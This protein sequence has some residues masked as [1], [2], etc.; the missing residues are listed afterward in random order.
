[1][2]DASTVV[3]LIVSLFLFMII[4]VLFMQVSYLND[5]LSI[6]A[7]NQKFSDPNPDNPSIRAYSIVI[8]VEATLALKDENPT[9]D[10]SN[11]VGQCVMNQTSYANVVPTGN[12]KAYWIVIRGPSVSA[13]SS[14]LYSDV[15]NSKT[16]YIMIGR[17]T[18]IILVAPNSI[19][20]NNARSKALSKTQSDDIFLLVATLSSFN[21]SLSAS[22]STCPSSHRLKVE[23]NSPFN[24]VSS[25]VDTLASLESR[26]DY[27][28]QAWGYSFGQSGTTMSVK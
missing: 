25:I 3:F 27:Y 9:V 22:A 14:V 15:L 19:A 20:E 26:T 11:Q 7:M 8:N 17:G 2:F 1:M 23:I 5:L 6:P 12:F 21:S 28:A 10:V 13:S 4:V 18:H 16:K 24:S